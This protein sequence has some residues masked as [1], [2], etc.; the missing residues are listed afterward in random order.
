MWE[1]ED[2]KDRQDPRP[3]SSIPFFWKDRKTLF[4]V[5]SDYRL[6]RGMKQSIK[7]SFL[8]LRSA[9]EPSYAAFQEQRRAT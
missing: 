8:V 5:T 7:G 4:R 2:W 9:P 1:I 6:N 3:S